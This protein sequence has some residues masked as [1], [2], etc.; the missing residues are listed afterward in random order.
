MAAEASQK[1]GH[2]VWFHHSNYVN[3][4]E[5]QVVTVFRNLGF[6][7]ALWDARDFASSGFIFTVTEPQTAH[8]ARP[9]SMS[10]LGY[11]V[12]NN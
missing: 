5:A 2:Q 10:L 1:F 11:R 9:V 6:D 12:K 7:E 4:C 3:E 8:S